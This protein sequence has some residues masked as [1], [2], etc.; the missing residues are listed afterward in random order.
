MNRR[1][2]DFDERRCAPMGKRVNENFLDSYNELDRICSAKFGIATGGVTEYINRL[3]EA[4]Y[5]LGRDKV[6]PRLVR[7][8]SIR[9]RFAHEVGAL[10]KLDE[11]S[12]AD[13]SWLK[14]F[15]YTVRHRRDPISAYLR[16]ARKYVRHKKLR[17]ALYI[18]GA[19]VIAALA[20]ALYFVLSR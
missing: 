2:K 20:I 6:L 4:K 5:A 1:I 17:H 14:R 18:G 10:R 15:S 19:V 13:V 12:R 9:N 16:K 7:Y 8:R 11:L 3:N